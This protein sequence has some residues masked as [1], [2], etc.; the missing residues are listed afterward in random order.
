MAAAAGSD[1]KQRAMQRVILE[2]NLSS[3]PKKVWDVIN[4]D[5]LWFYKYHK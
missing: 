1:A 4:L 5:K 3:L 2:D